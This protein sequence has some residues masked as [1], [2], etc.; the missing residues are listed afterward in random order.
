MRGDKIIYVSCTK[1]L[2]IMKTFIS[3][4]L[5]S[6]QHSSNRF[7]LSKMTAKA[8]ALLTALLMPF[9]APAQSPVGD[10]YGTLD[11]GPAR[12][13]M[14]LHIA[15]DGDGYSSTLDSP[16]QNAHGIPT[17]STEVVGDT[18]RI[19]ADMLGMTFDGRLA[20]DS[21]RGIFRQGYLQ[22][23]LSF[24]RRTTAASERPQTPQPPF[25]YR[26]EEVSFRNPE[27]GI[28]LAGTL[29]IPDGDGP[30]PAAILISGSG[31]Q[32]RNEEVFGHKPFLILAD[33]LARAG[34]A[35][36]RYDDRGTGASRG[37]Y[38]TAALGD[39]ASDA[40]SALSWLAARPETDS[41]RTGAIGHSDGGAIVYMLAGSGEPRPAFI[42][43]MAGPGVRGDILLK[44]QRRLIAEAMGVDSAAVAANESLVAALTERIKTLTPEYVAAHAAEIAEELAPEPIR[45]DEAA[46]RAF[47]AKVAAAASPELLSLLAY[48]PVADLQAI[49]CPVMALSG[50][51]D[52]QVP[53]RMALDP[54]RE[55]AVHAADV[56]LRLYEGLNH[57]FQ[58]C[59][60]GLPT[61]YGA[62]E[63]T[64]SEEVAADI[65]SWIIGTAEH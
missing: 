64:M 55:H 14:V 23:D 50:S 51:R 11:L 15:S 1:D 61:E 63:E 58:H 60:T 9:L 21:L 26:S 47:T 34:I 19:A 6:P 35:V 30:F 56:T 52:L 59:A 45:G 33:R 42:V 17:T 38:A 40:R 16:D 25:P 48:D 36:L 22:Q 3:M 29:F 65:A 57:L 39:F 12:L 54:V 32:N 4:H 2:R 37:S 7:G 20:G 5:F 27:A 28:T 13:R 44:E 41:S 10:W 53:S 24:T 49:T 46:M 31:A 62:I 18:V 43:S 8:A